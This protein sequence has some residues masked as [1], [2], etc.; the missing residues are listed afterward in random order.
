MASNGTTDPAIVEAFVG[1]AHRDLD[2]V[3]E[4]LTEDKEL[5]NATWDW[6]GG[7]WETALGAAAH[8]GR[9]DIAEHLLAHGAR[10][11]VFAAA[12]LGELDVVKAILAAN[13]SARDFPG[14]HGIPLLDH[15]EC[16][17]DA[18]APVVEHLQSLAAG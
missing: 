2:R 9:R 12:M 16:G 11:D 6:G 4:M 15:A 17:G 8:M 7:D 10:M 13:P 14:P 3:T 5:A 18:A 1:A